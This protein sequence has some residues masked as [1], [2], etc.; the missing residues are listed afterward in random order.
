MAMTLH[1]AQQAMAVLT[2]SAA[3]LAVAPFVPASWRP[4]CGLVAGVGY[5]VNHQLGILSEKA[6]DK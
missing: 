1:G 3:A 5:I 4:W 2:G 6:G